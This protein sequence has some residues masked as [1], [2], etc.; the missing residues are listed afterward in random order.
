MF[1]TDN[2]G[3][4]GGKITHLT[5][6]QLALME[7]MVSLASRSCCLAVLLAADLSM[8]TCLSLLPKLEALLAAASCH[9]HSS[10][11]RRSSCSHRI[12]CKHRVCRSPTQ[13]DRLVQGIMHLPTNNAKLIKVRGT[14]KGLLGEVAARS[15]RFVRVRM[16]RAQRSPRGSPAS[17]GDTHTR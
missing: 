8:P 6:S 2:P 3:S 14:Y 10:C 5:A 4:D 15:S 11:H 16:P 7:L 17:S 9:C 12:S 13:A 1:P